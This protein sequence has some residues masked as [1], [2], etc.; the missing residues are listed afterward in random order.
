MAV[1]R[2]KSI[3]CSN[4]QQTDACIL[5]LIK[6]K[7]YF[8]YRQLQHSEILC[9]AHIA[10]MCFVWISEQTIITLYSID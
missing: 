1:Y 7:T 4:V 9:S 10:F 8:M 3:Y 6:L 5:N 2:D